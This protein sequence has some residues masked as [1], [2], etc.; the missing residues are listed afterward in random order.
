[1]CVYRCGQWHDNQRFHR[2]R[3]FMPMDWLLVE[4]NKM[5]LF[6]REEHIKAAL[7]HV[8]M[9]PER[10]L[11]RT[12]DSLVIM[13]NMAS[14]A[15]LRNAATDSENLKFIYCTYSNTVTSPCIISWLRVP[16]VKVEFGLIIKLPL[17]VHSHRIVVCRISRGKLDFAAAAAT[18][19]AAHLVSS[20]HTFLQ[21]K[22]ESEFMSLI[23][24]ASKGF[25]A[26]SQYSD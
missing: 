13:D 20:Q 17:C 23:Q 10:H 2:D 3:G 12:P 22:R 4:D 16:S 11:W 15:W 14:F 5:S 21:Q 26:Q 25:G 8:A 18:V 19:V 7:S 24:P 9:L 1:M 6:V